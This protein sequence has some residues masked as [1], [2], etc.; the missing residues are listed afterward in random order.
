[1]WRERGK[2]LNYK[3]RIHMKNIYNNNPPAHD[4]L[5]FPIKEEE[6]GYVGKKQF[7]DK[8]LD[9]VRLAPPTQ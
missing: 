9:R 7:W 5:N 6:A 1:M 4:R 2:S 8:H 3:E